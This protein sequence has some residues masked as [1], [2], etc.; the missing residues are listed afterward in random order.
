MCVCV[1]VCESV[2]VCFPHLISLPCDFWS[3]ALVFVP[4]SHVYSYFVFC[5]CV[6]VHPASVHVGEPRPGVRGE[7][8]GAGPP[9]AARTSGSGQCGLCGSCDGGNV[10]L[11]L[12]AGALRVPVWPACLVQHR[13]RTRQ[14]PQRARAT[15]QT[16]GK[17]AN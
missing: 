9:A 12:A 17:S 15:E 8:G 5:V 2:S 7:E 14:Q 6:Y 10:H 1:C 4:F 13:G 11:P 16:T 3:H